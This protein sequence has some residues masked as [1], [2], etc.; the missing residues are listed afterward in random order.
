VSI[1]SYI[2]SIFKVRLERLALETCML[3]CAIA[4]RATTGS[5]LAAQ[6]C[7]LLVLYSPPIM[8]L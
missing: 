3:G 2:A 4:R 7:C 5:T 8:D 1:S 6:L